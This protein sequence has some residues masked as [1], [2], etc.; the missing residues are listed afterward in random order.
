M[1]YFTIHENNLAGKVPQTVTSLRQVSC[2]QKPGLENTF[3]P[4]LYEIKANLRVS[5]AAK[6]FPLHKMLSGFLNYCREIK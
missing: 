2:E 4:T 5:L 1:F 3:M 6:K